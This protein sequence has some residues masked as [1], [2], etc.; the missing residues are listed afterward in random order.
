MPAFS[1]KAAIASARV[2]TLPIGGLFRS[3]PSSPSPEPGKCP[4]ASMKPGSSVRPP[5]SCTIAPSP[6]RSSISSRLPTATMRS[7]SSATASALRLLS[8]IVSTVPFR[9]IWRAGG[10]GGERNQYAVQAAAS[11][12]D[13]MT[14]SARF[15]TSLL[16][17][18]ARYRRFETRR[19]WHF[20]WT[21]TSR[22][23]RL[24]R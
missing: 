3:T 23:F 2:R 5:I 4:C 7:P 10:R 9:K 22:S 18:G 1:R 20:R 14:T 11:T 8:S 13:A 6:K 24:S 19:L 17:A 15:M 12:I 16:L 21:W